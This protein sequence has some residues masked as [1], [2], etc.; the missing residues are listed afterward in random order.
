MT[1][2]GQESTDVGKKQK[3]LLED[4]PLTAINIAGGSARGRNHFTKLLIFIRTTIRHFLVFLRR[5]SPPASLET[6]PARADAR[7]RPG[8]HGEIH[9]S[10]PP[11]N[12]ECCVN[13]NQVHADYSRKRSIT[14]GVMNLSRIHATLSTGELRGDTQHN[15]VIHSVSPPCPRAL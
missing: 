5:F 9:I 10:I 1:Y 12:S 14:H 2:Y 8:R 3:Q 13:S 15:G 6:Q 4:W 11:L 7:S